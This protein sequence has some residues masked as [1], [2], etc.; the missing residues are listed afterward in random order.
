MAAEKP[1]KQEKKLLKVD[2]ALI[3]NP[4]LFVEGKQ[5]DSTGARLYEIANLEGERIFAPSVTTCL[6]S[7]PAFVLERWQEKVGKRYADQSLDVAGRFGDRIDQSVDRVVKN[8]EC[9]KDHIYERY[10][11]ELAFMVGTQIG[12]ASFEFGFAGTLDALAMSKEGKLILLDIKTHGRVHN[13]EDEKLNYLT[14]AQDIQYHKRN[15]W[16]LQL[17]AYSQGL[18]ETFGLVVEE[19]EI[20]CFNVGLGK[21]VKPVEMDYDE[22][23]KQFLKFKKGI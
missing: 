12:V 11:D 6:P 2:G 13:P 18:L 9:Y 17:S 8:Q 4:Q 22:I 14:L 7:P 16:K 21:V 15:K 23:Q 5:E 3:Q 10:F 1:K 19:A 20:W